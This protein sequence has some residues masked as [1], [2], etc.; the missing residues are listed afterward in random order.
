[1][2]SSVV[3]S[4]AAYRYIITDIL[5]KLTEKLTN[6]RVNDQYKIYQVYV[7]VKTWDSWPK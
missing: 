3:V 1:M 4:D 6:P 2:I 5:E 7:T